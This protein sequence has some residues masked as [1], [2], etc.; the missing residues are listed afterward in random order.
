M[1]TFDRLQPAVRDQL[2]V[3]W[4]APEYPPHPFI[5]RPGLPADAVARLQAAMLAA[6]ADPAGQAALKALTLN[7]IGVARDSDYDPWRALGMKLPD[8]LSK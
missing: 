6:D 8:N 5:A 4:S 1:K 2:R 3:L 7:G